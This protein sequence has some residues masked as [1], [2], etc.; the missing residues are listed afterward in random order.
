MRLLPFTALTTW[1]ALA[2]AAAPAQ[3]GLS[4]ERAAGLGL[5]ASYAVAGEPADLAFGGSGMRAWQ[6]SAASEYALYGGARDT[7]GLRASEIYGGVVHALPRGWGS[8]LE[9][10]QATESLVSPRRYSLTGQVYTPMSDGRALSVGLKYRLDGDAIARNGGAGD[11]PYS[12][13]YS[14][15]PSRL[16]GSGLA[17]S[18]QLQMSFQYSA[19]GTVGLAMGREVETFTPIFD[20]ASAAGPRQYTLT[21]QHWLTPSWALS[22]DLLTQDPASPLRVQGL[23]LGVRYRF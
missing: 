6:L 2:A 19:A 18:Y 11:A 10:A 21:G 12:N 16:P 1:L 23:R 8:T 3:T 20:P 13:S 9:I 5:K 15:A 7:P 14:L 17:S 4:F 22:Y